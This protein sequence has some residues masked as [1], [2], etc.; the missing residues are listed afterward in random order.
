MLKSIALLLSILSFSIVS[1]QAKTQHTS[2]AYTSLS[3]KGR[4]PEISYR[5][6]KIGR[7]WSAVSNFGSYGDPSSEL[8]S[9]DWPGGTGVYYLWEGR[10][11]IG[12][13]LKGCYYV[14][15]IGI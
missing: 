13:E 4:R 2:K 15:H 12:A 1:V 7:V 8:P 10:L 11:W 9:Y 14:S 3:S 6:H 5:V